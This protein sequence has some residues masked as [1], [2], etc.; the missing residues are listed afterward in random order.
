MIQCKIIEIENTEPKLLY[1]KIKIGEKTKK[2][3]LIKPE[4]LGQ[5]ILNCAYKSTTSDFFSTGIRIRKTTILKAN[6][7]KHKSKLVYVENITLY[8][9]ITWLPNKEAVFTLVFT[10][11]PKHCKSF[12]LIENIPENGFVVRDIKRNKSDVYSINVGAWAK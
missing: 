2:K 12:D 11:L 6:D 5:V 1:P 3:L 7:S 10:G 8:P 9:T 4:E